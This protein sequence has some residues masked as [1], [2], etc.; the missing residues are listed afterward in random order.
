MRTDRRGPLAAAIATFLLP[1]AVATRSD[2]QL[3]VL[4]QGSS[5]DQLAELVDRAGGTVTH[6]LPII[7]AV[8]A[9]MTT[10]QLDEVLQSPVVTRHIDD[11]GS[12]DPAPEEEE[13]ACRVRGHLELSE[14]DS[15]VL[16]WTLHNKR[17]APV[18][19]KEL[20]IAWP[21]ALGDIDTLSLHGKPLTNA[22]LET[23]QP[24]A[25]HLQFPAVGAP[26][27]GGREDLVIS[28]A[29]DGTPLLDTPLRQRDFSIK[30]TFRGDCST[31][32]IPGYD[33][34]HDDFYYTRVAGIEPLHRE[35]ITGAGITVAVVDSGM[36]EHPAL[37][38]DTRGNSR[39]LA[40]YNAR[41]SDSGGPVIDESGH[42]T[43]MA[44]IIANSDPTRRD[45]VDTGTFKGV[46]PDAN[47]VVVKILDREGQA[48]LLEIVQGIQWVVDNRER[49]NIRVLNLSFAQQP[50]WPFW[51]DPVNQAV[52]RAWDEGIVVVAA[53][54]NEGPEPMTVG[55]PANLPLI[56]SVG[57]VTDSW[58]PETR[59]DDYIPDFSSQGPTPTGHLKPDLVALGGHMTGLI[60]PGSALLEEQ[61]ED[62]LSTGEYVS[63]GSSQAAAL[64]SGIAALLL[65]LDPE[66]TP[67][68][69]K[70]MLITSAE[71]AINRD[72]R[73]AY[74]PFQQG[75]GYASASR[76]VTLGQTH[77]TLPVYR[78][79]PIDQ[80]IDT[81]YGPAIVGEDGEPSLPGI[82]DL[83]A[84]EPSAKGLSTTRKW[85]VK[86]HI[87]RMD[88]PEVE[89]LPTTKNGINWL[90][91]YLLERANIEELG[92]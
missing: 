59:D 15:Q 69:V 41:D 75:Y 82:R 63:T 74:S 50:R 91:V 61:P 43:H 55:S 57:V 42:G 13:E 1:L 84:S 32:L 27:L 48:H 46:A 26:T 33:N 25:A 14:L 8:G 77:C 44:S 21:V 85:G 39:L 52:T 56:I 4:V 9:R 90:D 88:N 60:A 12:E 76:A 62:I 72:G 80:L 11:L 2:E 3:L 70:C 87:E 16:R 30:A 19:L 5:A 22:L 89:A 81:L 10:A 53:A 38:D 37:T 58:T 35:G 83:V 73:F 34:N 18:Q 71:P 79:L 40:T 36:W 92:Q 31:D 54:G 45:G 68:E 64:V 66:L 78:A 24:G 29:N 20:D 51:D 86:D 67:D 65:Q 17:D 7:Q 47:L 28:F 23:R 6:H 49:Y